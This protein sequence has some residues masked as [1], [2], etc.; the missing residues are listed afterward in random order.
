MPGLLAR[1]K[2]VFRSPSHG[3]SAPFHYIP[4][5]L[6]RNDPALQAVYVSDY[7]R[8]RQDITGGGGVVRGQLATM[9]GPLSY[10]LKAVPTVGV[11]QNTGQ[12]ALQ[13][14]TTFGGAFIDAGDVGDAAEIGAIIQ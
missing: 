11:G 7:A 14:T 9:P 12:Y 4:G 3:P 13:E 2:A 6:Y 5:P 10:A 8:P 1:L